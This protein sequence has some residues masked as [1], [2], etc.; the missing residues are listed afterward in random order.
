[1]SPINLPQAL[2][3]PDELAG[4]LISWFDPAQRFVIALSGGVDSAVVAAA[5]VHAKVAVVVVTARGPSVS[6]TDLTDAERLA[7]ALGVEHQWLETQEH[8]SP[9]YR[10]NDAKRCY[11]CKSHLFAAIERKFADSAIILTG[12]NRDDLGDY[13]PGL[14]AARQAHVRSP[15][16]ELGL[17]KN[18][19]RLLAEY[20]QLDV[21]DKPAS[22]CLASRI[23]YGVEVTPERLRRIELAE[24]YLKELIGVNDCRVRLHAGE[25]AR[26]EV[27]TSQLAKLVEVRAQLVKRLQEWGFRYVT[28]DWNGL[29][30]G[31]LNDVLPLEIRSPV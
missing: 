2:T 7:A 16:A 21:A 31:S 17:G 1:M 6:R 26:I 9:D 11:H 20:W 3:V 19:V 27:A 29:R 5:A 10:R 24:M 8:L 30:T 13:R 4:Q 18:E 22:P 23:A 28:I 12:T 14:E 25:L 15:L